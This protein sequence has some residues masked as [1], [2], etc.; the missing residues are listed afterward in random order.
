LK[1]LFYGRLGDVV[2]HELHVDAAS[3][4]IEQLRRRIIADHPHAQ[5]VLMNK[6][7]RVYVGDVLVGDDHMVGATD[8]VEFL[9][10]VSGG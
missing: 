7:A 8:C 5:E 9:A 6:R 3:C 10:P 4:S 2:G 1:V